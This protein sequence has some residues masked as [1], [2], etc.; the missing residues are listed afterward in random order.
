MS[1]TLLPAS[2][3]LPPPEL[4]EDVQTER[5][6][7]IFVLIAVGLPT[8]VILGLMSGFIRDLGLDGNFPFL[9]LDLNMPSLLFAN[10]PTG[11]DMGAH[12]LLPQ[13][14]RDELLPSGKIL[15]WSSAWYAGFPALYFYFPLPALFTVLADVVVP[16][17]VAF[18][19]ST[20]VGLVLLPTSVY[21]L[22]RG[23]GYA[24]VVAGFAA[25]GGSMFAFME[26]F[27]IYG[28]NIKS[29]LAGEFSFS[30]SL[31]LSLFYLGVVV[32]ATREDRP[33][34]PAAG[35]LL[36]LTALSHLVTTLVIIIASLPLLLRR[37]ALKTVLPSW[38]LGFALAAFWAVPLLIRGV[39]Q[40]LTTD[41][42]WN[43]VEG[44]VGETSSPGIVATPFPDEFVP[45]A[46]LGLIGL[47]WALLRRDDVSTL[48]VMTL[49]AVLMYRFL[50]DWTGTRLYNGRLLPYWYLGGFIFAGIALGLAV[51]ALSRM[52]PQRQQALVAVAALALIVPA[53]VALF[54]VNDAPGWVNWNFTGYEAKGGYEEYAALNRTVDGL[55]PGRVMWEHNNDIHNAYGTPMALMLLPYWDESHP[56]MEGVFF[57]SSITTP[58]HFL[59]Q[60]EMS[61]S[62]SR[63]VRDLNYS[64]MNMERGIAHLALF[65]VEYYVSVTEEATDAAVAANLELVAQTD[66]WTVFRLPESSFVDVAIRQPVVYNGVDDFKDVALDWYDDIR[67]FDYWVTAD[68]PDEWPRIDEL[69]DRFDSGIPLDRGRATVTDVV[70]ENDSISFTTDAI[71]VPHIVKMSYFPNWTVTEG[72]EGPY[73][74]APSLMVVVPTEER[75]VLQFRSTAVENVGNLLTLAGIAVIA[76]WFWRRRRDA[77]EPALDL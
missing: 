39:L 32:K 1:T 12:V 5:G 45:I 38:G 20:I 69:G 51:T 73:A 50:P 68:G 30:W 28:G 58:F 9:H 75:V 11:G 55:E 72:G 36:A 77:K 13:I 43:P 19:L 53:N 18:K 59:N 21:V 48:V 29:T 44:L 37:S 41:M 7:K 66:P 17:G 24:R 26:S 76:V 67:F 60:A 8:V 52:Y 22:S 10:T 74:A 64:S 46:V 49:S 15:G 61:Q 25:F 27:A 35:V 71:G 54:G 42:K 16:Y 6:S 23:L 62:P 40:D 34:G 56:S 70:V 57:E 14:L 65:D 3:P 47:V 2:P 4:S 63:P 33:F 31:A